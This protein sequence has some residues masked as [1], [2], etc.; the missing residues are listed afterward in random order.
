MKVRTIAAS[1]IALVLTGCSSSSLPKHIDTVAALGKAAE[2][3]TITPFTPTKAAHEGASCVLKNGDDGITLLT[4]T[5]TAQR[6]AQ[7]KRET[8]TVGIGDDW[9][10]VGLHAPAPV[11]SK[12]VN[13]AVTTDVA[14]ATKRAGGTL[15]K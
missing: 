7:L 13:D 1:G 12:S 5:S 4:F 11:L 8:D 3:R 6:D 15:S 14:T 2:C 9:M 10:I